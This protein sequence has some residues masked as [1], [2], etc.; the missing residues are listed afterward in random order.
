MIQNLLMYCV[1]RYSENKC[2]PLNRLLSGKKTENLL[3]ILR[4]VIAKN[5]EGIQT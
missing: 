5:Y 1:N 3:R 4:G 2:V